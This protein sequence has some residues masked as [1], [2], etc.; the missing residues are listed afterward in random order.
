MFAATDITKLPV[1]SVKLHLC[2]CH[3]TVVVCVIL[4][5]SLILFLLIFLFLFFLTAYFA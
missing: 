4:C 5:L 2:C 3:N 1:I